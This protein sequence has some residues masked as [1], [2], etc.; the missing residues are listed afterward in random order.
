V[1]LTITPSAEFEIGDTCVEV[2]TAQDYSYMPNEKI[3]AKNQEVHTKLH[4]S[5]ALTEE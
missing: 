3:R 4:E 2:E 1:Y 5:L